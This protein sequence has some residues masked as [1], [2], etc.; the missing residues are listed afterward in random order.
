MLTQVEITHTFN[1]PRKLVFQ[2]FTESEHLK[3]WW[4]P[5]GW[6]FNVLKSDFRSG[7]VFHYSQK[8]A[9]GNDMWVKFVYN[10]IIAPVNIVYTSFFS[11]GEDNMLRAPFNENWPLEILNTMR[12]HEDKGKTTLTAIIMPA[13][14]ATEEEL[15]TFEESRNMVH[16]GFSG[17]FNQLDDYLIFKGI[18]MKNKQNH[19]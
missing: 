3:Q 18:E 7:G 6:T 13:V 9:D 8:P 12:F 11:D 5:K 10:E 4:G 19:I 14:S 1:A 17:T 15:K 2:A 16:E